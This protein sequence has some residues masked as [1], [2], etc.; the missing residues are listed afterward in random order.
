MALPRIVV[1]GK[2]VIL[3]SGFKDETKRVDETRKGVIVN[4]E[5]KLVA[6]AQRDPDAVAFGYIAGEWVASA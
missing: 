4:A 2:K 3:L 6:A 1:R 5:D